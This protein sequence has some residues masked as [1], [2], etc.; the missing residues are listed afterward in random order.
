MDSP[1]ATLLCLSD[2]GMA[3]LQNACALWAWWPESEA[4]VM[5]SLLPGKFSYNPWLSG[6]LCEKKKIFISLERAL[7]IQP[8]STLK[9]SSFCLWPPVHGPALPL[10]KS[11]GPFPS[12]PIEIKPTGDWTHCRLIDKAES[13]PGQDPWE[14]Y[15][16]LTVTAPEWGLGLNRYVLNHVHRS[17]RHNSQKSEVTYIHEQM[18]G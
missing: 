14:F 15:W 17:I 13:C 9:L 1:L 16:G 4:E 10:E 6:G 18:D 2:L 8:G 11:A 3:H 12:F 7:N 5:W